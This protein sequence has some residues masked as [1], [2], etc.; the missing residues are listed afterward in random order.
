MSEEYSTAELG[1]AYSRLSA[2]LAE[3]R[4]DRQRADEESQTS[5]LRLLAEERRTTETMLTRAE[6]DLDR[7]LTVLEGWQTWAIRIVV[8]LVLAAV[9]GTVLV[10][11]G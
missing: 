3:E 7:R 1:R 8:G 9:V 11:A 2:D 10:T 5:L 4:R 6:T